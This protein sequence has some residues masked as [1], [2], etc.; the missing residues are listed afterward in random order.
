M[1]YGVDLIGRGVM[2]QD[3]GNFFTTE[4]TLSDLAGNLLAAA[5]IKYIKF[6]VERVQ[7]GLDAHEELCYF[8]EDGVTEIPIAGM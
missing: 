2:V 8:V 7:A 4:C 3:S 6:S 1:P 5:T